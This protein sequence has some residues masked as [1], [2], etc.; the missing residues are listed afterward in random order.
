M[1]IDIP[2]FL[3][4]VM[5]TTA[6]AVAADSSSTLATKVDIEEEKKSLLNNKERATTTT[7]IPEGFAASSSLSSL[8]SLVE[9]SGAIRNSVGRFSPPEGIPAS[10]MS[11]SSSSSLVEVSDVI[12]ASVGRFSFNGIN[13]LLGVVDSVNRGDG[14]SSTTGTTHHTV[15]SD[16][17]IETL[18]DD[19]GAFSPTG[20]DS[21][22]NTGSPIPQA[23]SS[24]V[25]LLLMPSTTMVRYRLL[26]VLTVVMLLLSEN[27]RN[28]PRKPK[29]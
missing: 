9:V 20:L 8:S 19:S 22:A 16:V 15:S 23:I 26:L 29:M 10:S 6:T 3:L 11:S 13:N 14:S 2:K 25:M 18:P 24:I 7:T 5:M 12:H 1:K 27:C 17:L 21:T 4:Y 28:H